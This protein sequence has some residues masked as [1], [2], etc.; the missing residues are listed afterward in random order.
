MI[1]DKILGLLPGNLA[2]FAIIG[3][4]PGTKQNI[5]GIVLYDGNINTEYFGTRTDSTVY[6]PVIK[7]VVRHSSYETGK[8]WVTQVKDALHRYHDDEILSILL[9]GS[10]MYLGKSEEKLHTFQVTF[11]LQVKE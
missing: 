4:L 2:S 6:R 10:P 5:I 7:V 11:S 8:S 9:V 1:E 3:D